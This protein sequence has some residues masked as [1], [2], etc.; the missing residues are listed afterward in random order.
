[1][2]MTVCVC[3]PILP[4]HKSEGKAKIQIVLNQINNNKALM[5]RQSRSTFN[6]KKDIFPF[7]TKQAPKQQL[8]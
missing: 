3:N 8:N 5:L 1:M 6:R 4:R 7:P 2:D